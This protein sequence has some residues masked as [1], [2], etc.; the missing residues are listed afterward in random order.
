VC[1]ALERAYPHEGC[2]V[3]LEG[4]QGTRV[5]VLANA[6]PGDPRFA[7]AFEPR[8]WLRTSL[9]AEARAERV[10]WV[11]HSHVDGPAHLSA[12]DRVAAA[13]GGQLLLPGVLQLVIGVHA[14]RACEARAYRWQD[15][16]FREA[17]EWRRP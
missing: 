6:T 16:D 15:G 11:F 2:G 8:E 9:E 10:G 17:W 14:G 7:F 12:A 1:A 5:Q 3:V 13:P 4:A